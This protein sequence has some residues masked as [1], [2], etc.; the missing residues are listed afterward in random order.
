MNLKTVLVV[1]TLLSAFSAHAAE[2]TINGTVLEKGTRNPLQG[3]VVSVQ[4]QTVLS[5]V[6]DSRGHFQITLPAAGSYNLIASNSGITAKL[7]VEVIE[8]KAL[9][10]PTFYLRVPETL[11][12][13]VVTAERSPDQ[14]SKNDLNGKAVRQLAGSSGDPL[15][16]LQTLPGVA[17]VG[18]SSAPAVRGSGPG[19]NAYYVDGL[20]INRLFHYGDISVFNADLIEDFNLYSAA[21]GPHYADV[22][23]AVID[24]A[25]REPRKD[26]LGGKVDVNVMGANFLAEGPRTDD[27][28]F[29]FA[30]R[31]SYVD[32]LVKQVEDKGVTMQVPHYWDY[33]GKYLWKLNDTSRLTFH[34]Q[35]ASDVLKLSIAPSAEVAQTQPVLAGNAAFSEISSMQ[36]AV[37]DTL[38]SGGSNNTLSFE[39]TNDHSSSAL[40]TA[41]TLSLTQDNLR[42]HD[43]VRFELSEGHEL[44]LGTELANTAVKIN[45]DF[46]NATCTQFNPNC[47]LTSATRQQL[48]DE[49]ST[50][51]MS[52]SAQDRKRVL[53]YLTLI[54][55]LRYSKENYA[56]KS[57]TEPRLGAEW[58]WSEQ[59]L[60]TAGWGRHNQYPTDA[61]WVRVF[62]NPMLDHIRA[63][64]SVLGVKHKVDA[65]WNWKAETYY[66]K[67]SNLVVNDPALNY[68]NAA[69]GKAYGLELLIKKEET[70]KLSGW[71]VLNLAK[72][73]RRDD[74]TGEAFRFEYDQPINTTL[75]GTYK[76]S[77]NWSLGGK[78]AF[79]SGTPYT[80]IV[81]TS[82]NYSDGR[83]IPV[84]AAVNSGTLPVYHRLDLRLDRNY[85]FDKWKFN[86]YFELNNI[87][88]RKEIVGYTYNAN[89]TSKEPVY[90]FV[91]PFSFGIQGEF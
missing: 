62:G 16:A 68:I 74:V 36:A 8:G 91:L 4:D 87:Y 81:G 57:Y 38:L 32:L 67:F 89:Y 84:Y 5:A 85:V 42:L 48:T 35:G 25:L 88:Q 64:H 9:P 76:L 33:Q 61:Q 80:P 69:S 24:V 59:T 43:L 52:V 18:G 30:A 29:Y 31:R 77:E 83:P 15:R 66:K 23:G 2:L 11:G 65:D 44:S 78:W 56:H 41:G 6:S 49:F 1:A 7:D 20:P 13:M 63:D 21:F 10:S 73:Q 46:L 34:M 27:Q 70:D 47:D 12:E 26:R 39:H 54:G 72:S 58:E 82:G 45:A 55:G 17:T 22:T 53:S 71:F 50:S 51:A 79:H 19:D 60:F 28:S 86:T 3:V 14:V 75:V 90:S 40:G 37:L